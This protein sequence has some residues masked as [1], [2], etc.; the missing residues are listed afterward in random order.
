L[1]NKQPQRK[2]ADL[3][4]R[5]DHRQHLGDLMSHDLQHS[6]AMV[7]TGWVRPS[8]FPCYFFLDSHESWY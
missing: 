3:M 7:P 4:T 6:L 2:L 1:E 8:C 5:V